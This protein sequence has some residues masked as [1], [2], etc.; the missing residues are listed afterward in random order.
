MFIQVPDS[1]NKS[2]RNGIKPRTEIHYPSTSLGNHDPRTVCTDTGIVGSRN[3]ID[4]EL[5]CVVCRADRVIMPAAAP[6]YITWR[7]PL[8]PS[9]QKYRWSR[10]YRDDLLLTTCSAPPRQSDTE[11]TAQKV[12]AAQ[13]VEMPARRGEC[14]EEDEIESLES[15]RS[16]ASS[17]SNSSRDDLLAQFPETQTAAGAHTP[18]TKSRTQQQNPWGRASYS[19]LITMAITSTNSNMMT[20]S[21]IYSWI[22]KNVPYFNDKGT[23]LSVQG[24]KNAVR[25]TLSLRKRFVRVPDPKRPYKSMWTISSD[26]QRNH[27]KEKRSQLERKNPLKNKNVSDK[28][29]DQ[30]AQSMD[31]ETTSEFSGSCA[32]PNQSQDGF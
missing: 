12:E 19:D 3:T 32:S 9:H 7:P 27:L 21:D 13:E 30:M 23:Y 5:E 10:D 24:W 8:L 16:F 1:V 25:H 20:L 15:P 29:S 28:E 31:F 4:G 14:N 17:G 22:V 11:S 6:N 18:V 26:Y 2:I